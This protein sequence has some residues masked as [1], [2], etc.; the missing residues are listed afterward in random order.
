MRR[1]AIGLAAVATLA[2]SGSALASGVQIRRV[3]FGRYPVVR[4]LVEA[5]KGV[6]PR[7]TEGG[8]RVRFARATSLGAENAVVLAI[9]NSQSMRGRPLREAV[10][11]AKSFIARTGDKAAI[12]SFAHEPLILTGFSFSA[13]KLV[14]ALNALRS[15]EVVGTSL[16]DAVGL[17]VERLRHTGDGTRVL[18]ILSDGRDLGSKQSEKQ[19]IEDAQENGVVVYPVALGRADRSS[20]AE[21]ARATGGRLLDAGTASRL[22]ST[23]ATI[24]SE[25][26]R[27]WQVE[28]PTAARPGDELKI[29]AVA[30]GR[31]D[32]A[33][34]TVPGTGGSRSGAFPGWFVHGAWSAVLIALLVG[35]IL[36]GA[37]IL[38]FRRPRPDA[39]KSMVDQYASG[40][41]RPRT[42]RNT[43][44]ETLNRLFDR[45][46]EAFE[47]LRGWQWL[48]RSIERAALPVRP[49]HIFFLGLLAAFVFGLLVAAAEV[50]GIVIGLVVV[51]ALV[52][53][54]LVV[55]VIGERRAQAFDEQLPDVLATIA[56]ALRVGHGLRQALRAVAEEG[57]PPASQEMSRVLAEERLG[58]PLNDAF[59]AMCERIGSK[60][61]D[62]ISTA[63]NVQSQVGGSLAFLFETASE[64]VRDRQRHRRRV[65]ALTAMGRSSAT[66]L[67][68]LPLVLAVVLTLTSPGYMG[69][70]WHTSSGHLLVVLSV[71]SIA[72]GGFIVSRI[73]R[74]ESG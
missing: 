44:R 40:A 5:P 30:A 2:A 66:V 3:D 9:D 68:S 10:A 73:A 19:I 23:Y 42:R 54:V 67:V 6:V 12:E 69:P 64:T 1:L 16:Y 70:L 55:R 57:S 28:Y 58:R 22:A 46:E 38:T 14:P 56:G 24:A 20:L 4:V 72:V 53:P 29:G 59:L 63:V 34:A 61:L 41:G 8:K 74:V 39:V 52:S 36:S 51:L 32:G 13:D 7:V 60:E 27:I 71:I 18:I 48:T 26:D 45:T 21:L 31:S 11:A 37:M 33:S 47:R 65:K 43:L 49:A 25:L 62:Y 17:G 15:D 35:A 50:P